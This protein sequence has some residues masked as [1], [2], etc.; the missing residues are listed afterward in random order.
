[1]KKKYKKI[2]VEITNKCNLKC[3]FCSKDKRVSREMKLDEFNHVLN[4]ISPYTD[5]IYLHVKGEPLL[6]SNLDDIL[7]SCTRKNINVNITT[8]GT[9]LKKMLPI[10]LNNK[11][12]QINISLHAKQNDINYLENAIE[13][14][15]SLLN[16][17]VL[18]SYRLWTLEENKLGKKEYGLYQKLLKYYDVNPE[19]IADLEQKKQIEL[20]KNL[21]LNLDD[22]FCWPNLNNEYYSEIGT[23][24]G[25]RS[26]LAILSSGDVIPCCLDSSAKILLG[27]IFNEAFENIIVSEKVTTIKEGFQNNKKVEELCKHCN[28]IKD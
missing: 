27:N 19:E 11:I 26:H 17:Q 23:C 22:L 20:K 6:H 14:V 12:R 10:L 16:N 5:Y 2:Y 25:L 13:S 3:D 7:K 28:F 9:L 4:E 1:M 24:Y 8:N 21:Y 15:D 18:I